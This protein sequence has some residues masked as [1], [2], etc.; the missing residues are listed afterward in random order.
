MNNS[1]AIGILAALGSAASWSIGV[2][3]FKQLGESLSSFA[4]TLVQGVIGVVLLGGLTI[5]SGC[6]SN[7]SRDAYI[8]LVLS[9]ILGITISGPFFFRALKEVNPQTITL[10][11]M[12]GQVITVLLAVLL[13]G[14]KLP[15]LG[16]AG[17]ALVITGISIGIFPINFKNGHSSPRGLVLGLIS[18]ILMSIA[19]I[20][21]KEGLQGEISTLYATFIRT[22]AG[23]FGIL[24]VGV[25]TRRLGGWI[26]PF[27][28]ARL[29]WKFTLSVCIITFGG[30]WLAIV[31][32]KY[33]NVA[34][35]S[36]LIATEPIFALLASA[37]FFNNKITLQSVAGAF[38]AMAGILILCIGSLSS[39]T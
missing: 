6:F 17:I 34:V 37:L 29:K 27:R 8:Y 26:T 18:I 3:L 5:A 11:F 20:L 24:L 30:F 12:L 32:F 33:T 23:T 13:L 38:I 14:E 16:W 9:G 21:T 31:A 2:V 36:S 4:M 28:D 10:L 1:D 25:A 7:I 22:L 39:L 19:A 15:V 35:A